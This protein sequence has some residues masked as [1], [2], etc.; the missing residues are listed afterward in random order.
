MHLRDGFMNPDLD[1]ERKRVSERP[2]SNCVYKVAIGM[3]AGIPRLDRRPVRDEGF[4]PE[5]HYYNDY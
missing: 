5:V 1:R 3:E 4:S 2:C